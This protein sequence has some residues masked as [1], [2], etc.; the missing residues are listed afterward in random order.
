MQLIEGGLNP[1]NPAVQALAGDF[2]AFVKAL[3]S[4]ADQDARVKAFKDAVVFAK[5]AIGELPGP[6]EQNIDL[7]QQY[8]DSL[9]MNADG[10][11]GLA[12]ELER[13]SRALKELQDIEDSPLRRFAGD[14]NAL[15]ASLPGLGGVF[16]RSTGQIAEGL[17]KIAE[18]D[19]K[20]EGTAL[21]I[22]GVATAIE[23]ITAAAQDGGLNGNQVMELI[24]G[25]ASVAGE[26]IGALTGIPGLGQVVSAAFQLI[27][28]A[29]GDLSDG[30]AEIQEQVDETTKSTPLLA[31]STVD[32]FAQEYTRRVS[33]GGIAGSFGSTKAE[34]DEELFNAAIDLAGSF[35]TTFATA[36]AAADFEGSLDLGFD[37]MI[38]DQLIEA[39][40]LSPEVQAQIK[41]LVEFWQEAW[42]DGNLSD[43]ERKRWEALKQGLIESGR[44]TREQLKELGLLDDEQTKKARTGGARITDLTGP[45]R[46]HFSDLLAPLRHLGAQLSTLQ[47]I[48]NLLDARLPKVG[49]IG[50]NAAGAGGQVITIDTV[51]VEGVR[52][53]RT[54]FDQLSLIAKRVDRGR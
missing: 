36:L 53:V 49:S 2:E 26:A 15:A 1:A 28:A 51:R 21:V 6:L 24:G 16:A 27:T 23:G 5:D 17:H 40:I 39:F 44:A 35:A 3:Q 45:A 54:L 31:R 20:L 48:R 33:R 7:L 8:R 19:D 4:V 10:A 43:A 25:I 22:R 37:R 30:I 12:E 9:D 29:V 41:A 46:D 14:V 47:D 11:A 18:T 42:E 34:L 32:A 52:D 50:S 38:R 13:L